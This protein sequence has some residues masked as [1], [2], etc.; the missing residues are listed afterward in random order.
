MT[1]REKVKNEAEEE[2]RASDQ[3]E[4]ES[5]QAEFVTMSNGGIVT[6]TLFHVTGG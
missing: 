3:R 1:S 6:P 5:D 4:R 2:R